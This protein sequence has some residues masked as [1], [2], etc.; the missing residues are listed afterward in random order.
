MKN[1]Y[2][3]LRQ[4]N[5]NR[6]FYIWDLS[7]NEEITDCFGNPVYFETIESAKEYIKDSL[8]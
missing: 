3:I 5:Q 6:L 7:K 2:E 4:D 1:K 8:Q